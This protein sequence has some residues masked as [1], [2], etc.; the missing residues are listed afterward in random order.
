MLS[1]AIP[2]LVKYLIQFYTKFSLVWTVHVINIYPG[3]D[4]SMG[5]V[6]TRSFA[7][8]SDFVTLGTVWFLDFLC[9]LSFR[10]G[11]FF[12]ETFCSAHCPI[13]GPIQK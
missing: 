3:L 4:I 9:P 7:E 12:S 8:G 6:N 13:F 10:S 11:H 5:A 2:S 1:C